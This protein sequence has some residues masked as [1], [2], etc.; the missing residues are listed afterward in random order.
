MMTQPEMEL[1]IEKLKAFTRVYAT[2]LR[3]IR[4]RLDHLEKLYDPNR[5][6][7]PQE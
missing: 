6:G 7:E 2:A 1:E 3:Q 5:F 4:D